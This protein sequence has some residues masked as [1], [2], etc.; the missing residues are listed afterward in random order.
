VGKE[1]TFSETHSVVT[2]F[3]RQGWHWGGHFKTLKD[4]HHFDKVEEII[5]ITAL[6]VKNR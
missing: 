2:E 1:G 4:Y 6:D 5:R 3:Q